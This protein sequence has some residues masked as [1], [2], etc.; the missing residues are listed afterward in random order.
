M[1]L[2]AEGKTYP[3]DIPEERTKLLL[4]RQ[5][6]PFLQ[7]AGFVLAERWEDSWYMYESNTKAKIKE[8]DIFVYMKDLNAAMKLYYQGEQADDNT[9]SS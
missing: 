6:V 8:G 4:Y 1:K 7:Q 3:H 2:V 5:W 9:S